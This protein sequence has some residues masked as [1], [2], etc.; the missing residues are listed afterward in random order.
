MI[1]GFGYQGSVFLIDFVGRNLRNYPTEILHQPK[2]KAGLLRSCICQ[3]K[4]RGKLQ[5][6]SIRHL[7]V[8]D[9]HFLVQK[10]F[11]MFQDLRVCK[12]VR[13][14]T[15][16]RGYWIHTTLSASVTRLPPLPADREPT[17]RLYIRNFVLLL[18]TWKIFLE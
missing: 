13:S 16:G 9:N 15:V 6:K 2:R 8:N 14:M 7:Q 3:P 10:L 17:F 4:P 5:K 12:I 18:K 11:R 1:S